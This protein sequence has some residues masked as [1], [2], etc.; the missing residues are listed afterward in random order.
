MSVTEV[1]LDT[2][3]MERKVRCSLL[4]QGIILYMCTNAYIYTSKKYNHMEVGS[5][6]KERQGKPE[7]LILV[8]RY[9]IVNKI[10]VRDRIILIQSILVKYLS[11]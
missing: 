10:N 1:K 5:I 4:S 2:L 3:E 7:T 9:N 6:C 8:C 11:I